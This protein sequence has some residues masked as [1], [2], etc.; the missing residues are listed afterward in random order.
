METPGPRFYTVNDRPVAMVPTSNG[1]LDWVVFDWVTGELVPDRSYFGPVTPGSGRDTEV[2]TEAEFETRLAVYR[3]EAAVRA[4]AELR[5]WAERLCTAVGEPGDLAAALGPFEHDGFRDISL[6]LPPGG[7]RRIQIGVD[8]KHTRR[9]SVELA[10]AG[11]LLTR[12]VLEA[13]FHAGR[14]LPIPPDS[15]LQ[16]FVVYPAVTVADAPASC[17]ISAKFSSQGA[18]SIRLSTDARA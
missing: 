12:E 11:R 10:P 4:T 6:D 14:E 13:E 17:Q 2:L 18:V 9:A 7:Y 5:R 15:M 16:G 1:G 8:K 3:A